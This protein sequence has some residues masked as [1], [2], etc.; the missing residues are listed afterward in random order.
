MFH[1]KKEGM[2]L[3]TVAVTEAITAAIAH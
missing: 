3:I 2:V 1:W